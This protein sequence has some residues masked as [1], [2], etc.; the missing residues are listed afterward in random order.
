MA[1]HDLVIGYPDN[2]LLF[3]CPDLEIKRGDRIALIGPNGSGKTTLIKTILA[4]LE[5]QEGT[6]RFGSGVET[7]Y[8]AQTH[9]S[10]N[11]E[12]SILDEIL[13]VE[14]LPI[15]EARNYLGAFLFSGDDVFKPIETLSGGERSRVALAKLTLTGAN[16]LILDEPTNHLDI[17]S[18]E[19]LEGGLRNFG[20][21]ILLTSHDRYFID[22]VATHVWAL[23][24][25]TKS[26][27]VVKGG[28]SRYLALCEDQGNLNKNGHSATE[29]KSDNQISHQQ[30]KAKR[31]EAEKKG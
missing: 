10:L 30:S 29:I 14:N 18:Q 3:T 5:P 8:F 25:E 28:Y 31:R 1:T 17:P 15:G 27:R 23:E 16:F 11:L 2:S 6:I 7:G 21:T 12:A 9:A 24:P 4:Q 19:T 22:A 20:G 13:T 26:V